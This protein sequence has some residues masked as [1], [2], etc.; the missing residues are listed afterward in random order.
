MTRYVTLL[1]GIN[2]GG[3]NPIKMA[4]LKACFER[5][6]FE[7]VATYIQSGNVLFGS[8]DSGIASL[9]ERIERMLAA[10]FD[11]EASVVVRSR[12]QMQ[13]IVAEAPEGFGGD[14]VKHRSDVVFLK[15][16]LTPKAAIGEVST[17]EG[18]DRAWVG[19]RASRCPSTGA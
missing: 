17:G 11:Y 2:V 4:D 6:G 3:K 12:A 10:S 7:D 8:R 14:P 18:V 9:T 19:T 5:R 16:P 1:R 15:P 13:A